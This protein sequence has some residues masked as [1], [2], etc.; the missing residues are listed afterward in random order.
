MLRTSLLLALPLLALVPGAADAAPARPDLVTGAVAD[1]PRTV[2]AGAG[3]RVKDT[4]AN[5]GRARAGASTTR[6]YLAADARRS[7]RERKASKADPRRADADVLLGGARTVRALRPGARSA[8][9]RATPLTV[10]GATRPG[11]YHLLAC[12]DDR[13]AVRES[14]EAPNCRVA[15][16]RVTVTGPASDGEIR[17]ISDVG[18]LPGEADDAG[19]L[20]VFAATRCAAGP[21][22]RTMTPRAAVA[23]L[24]ATLTR[25]VGAADM[26]AFAASP[27]FRDAG[28]A[29]RAA[30]AG[31][32]AAQPGASLVAL[33]RA[34]ELQ[35]TRAAHLRNA[36]SVAASMGHASEA[37]ALLD[38]AARLDDRPQS[39]FGIDPRVAARS[40]RGQ[41]L[42]M[43]GRWADAR[44]LLQSA[45]DAEPLLAEAVAGV[46]AATACTEGPAKALA[47]AR[48]S[49]VRRPAPPL[50]VSRGVEHALRKLHLPFSPEQAAPARDV[51]REETQALLREGSRLSDRRTEIEANLRAE[52]ATSSSATRRRRAAIL[53]R[54]LD[55]PSEPDMTATLERLDG[56]RNAPH[57]T[58]YEFWGNG[59]QESRFR[60]LKEES[61]AACIGVKD[62]ECPRR[63]MRARCIP[64][65]RLKHQVWVDQVSD[66]WR[67]ADA[68][69]R[70]FS[71]KVSALGAHLS[72]PQATALIRTIIEEH[73]H[74]MYFSA[75]SS[76][77]GWTVPLHASQDDC[78]A[79]PETAPTPEAGTA[80]G[81]ETCSPFVKPINGVAKLDDFTL[82]VSCE[83]V[84]LGGSL[85]AAPWL[86][87]FA[88]AGYD[89]KSGKMTIF[90][91]AQLEVDSLQVVKGAFKS[92]I[93]LTVSRDGIED[94]GWRTGPSATAGAGP[95]EF[96]LYK[97][98]IDMSF[99]GA[100]DHLTGVR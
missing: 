80:A 5:R 20:Q 84:E 29:Q 57:E 21:A 92:G 88:E 67:A 40:T 28:R 75:R 3:F 94:I 81:S 79:Q 45:A 30:I 65:L 2:A 36:A 100:F 97:D 50:D 85:A 63:E 35:P 59:D 76:V 10:P 93:Y 54:I 34:H 46:A 55:V 71:K 4:A 66:V 1:P 77:I 8:A 48:R 70:L 56:L 95:V 86:A 53:R 60:Q 7:L 62:P 69:H 17:A 44:A 82:K 12:A 61:S 58:T 98:E 83:G 99:I 89:V 90:T 74:D 32:V 49:R 24:R 37:L 47:P 31:L 11:V 26:R 18:D 33:L 78:V 87:G 42:G 22:L 15:K 16:R 41:A 72:G 38:G 73:E 68:R 96:A 13:G 23:S 25:Q 19:A 6:F 39:G 43:A 51:Y 9:R 91:G 64:E 14:A 27:E 52:D